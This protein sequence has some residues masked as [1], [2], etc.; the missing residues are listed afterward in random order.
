MKNF[1]NAS[2][3]VT[4]GSGAI[5]INLVN[6]LLDLDAKVI[7]LDDFSQSKKTNLS[8]S[9][10]LIVIKGNI[11]NKKI[12]EKIFSKKIDY[13]FH[14]AARFANELSV[15]DPLEDLHV[16]IE[17]TLQVLLYAS[18]QKLKRFV[19]ASSS[20]LYGNQ[21]SVISEKTIP[22]PSTPYAVSKL[23]GE[24]YCKVMH[25]L[26]GLDYTVIRL[27]NSYG[28]FDPS[29]KYRNVI[30][31]FFQSALSNK[32]IVITGT[33]NE[34]RD[35]TYVDDTIKGILL[36]ASSRN[37]KNK[38]FNLG[39]G[40]ETSIK[41]IANIIINICNSKSKIIFKPQ[42][43]FDHINKRKMN[44]SKAQKLIGYNP[45]INIKEG[46]IKTHEWFLKN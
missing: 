34:T 8:F 27:S 10:N 45:S 28:P 1:K 39:T 30:P 3:L 19:Y 26:Y 43:S 35:F 11:T 15:K 6:K 46:L 44:I 32:D 29:G 33:G 42:R 37:S 9:K 40:K 38:I 41:K 36:A 23:T 5:G 22:N 20:S 7:V 21:K 12:L 13:V 31:N 4:G 25:E 17:G 2:V 24:Y 16:N 18:K 14:L